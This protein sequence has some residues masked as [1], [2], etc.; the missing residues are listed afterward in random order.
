[1]AVQIIQ[2]GDKFFPV[3]GLQTP[4]VPC[5]P[6]CT[7][8]STCSFR[9][10]VTINIEESVQLDQVSVFLLRIDVPD[11]GLCCPLGTNKRILTAHEVE[12][13]S[14]EQGVVKALFHKGNNAKFKR[15]ALY[16]IANLE[17]RATE[18][19]NKRK[20]TGCWKQAANR[21]RLVLPSLQQPADGRVFVSKQRNR[22]GVGRWSRQAKFAPECRLQ[23]IIPREALPPQKQVM[24]P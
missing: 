23:A 18:S 19:L 7:N 11:H 21:Q 10:F 1:M 2:T 13:A 15:P 3:P 4:A 5:M 22:Q 17:R 14:P 12:V 6:E 24:L 8:S 9:Q 16:N 20:S